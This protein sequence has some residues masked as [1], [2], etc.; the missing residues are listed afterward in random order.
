[1]LFQNKRFPTKRVSTRVLLLVILSLRF[2]LTRRSRMT[3]WI[4]VSVPTSYL[5]VALAPSRKLKLSP[6]W[7]NVTQKSV[8]SLSVMVQTML[9]WSTPLISVLVFKVWRALKLRELLI[10]L[11][12]S[13]SFWRIYF[14]CTG[15]NPT[16]KLPTWSLTCST[17]TSFMLFLSGCL[18]GSVFSLVRLSSPISYTCSTMWPSRPFPLFGSLCLTRNSTNKLF[19]TTLT[20]TELVL[21]ISSSIVAPSGVGSDTLSGKALFFFSFLTT[22]YKVDLTVYG[23]WANLKFKETLFSELLFSL[24]ISSCWSVPLSKL[25]ASGSGAWDLFL[26]TS[27]LTLYS[28]I[29]EITL[30]MA[31]S[32]TRSWMV[33][34]ICWFFS[35][36][37]LLFWSMSAFQWLMPKFATTCGRITFLSAALRK[38]NKRKTALKFQNKLTSIRV[39]SFLIKSLRLFNS[40]F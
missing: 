15:V 21:T 9:T 40:H 6:W 27:R 7:K 35:S 33:K 32:G 11:L 4:Y 25:L 22:L 13:S 10:T 29:L 37:L 26:F 31:L 2:N 18:D 24:S 8:P 16:A 23:K 1:M 12:A 19:W 30:V 14:L 17:R 38:A 3:S 36:A 5:L 28:A 34:L 20:F 39:S